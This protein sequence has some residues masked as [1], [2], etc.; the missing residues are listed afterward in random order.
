MQLAGNN[1]TAVLKKDGSVWV[2]GQNNYGQLG[3][4]NT[5]AKTS[6]V[7]VYAENGVDYLKDV[8]SIAADNCHMAAVLKDGSVYA[9][10]YNGYGQLRRYFD[11][12]KKTTYKSKNNK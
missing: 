5:T 12:I 2:S 1:F 3:I 7:R 9:W 11:K 4:G 8:I 6:F 10:G